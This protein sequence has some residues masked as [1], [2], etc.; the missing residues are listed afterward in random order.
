MTIVANNRPRRAVL[1]GSLIGAAPFALGSGNVRE[2]EPV[3]V[4]GDGGG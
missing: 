2:L 1:T 4:L 3:E